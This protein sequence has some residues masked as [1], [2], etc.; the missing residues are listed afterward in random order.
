MLSDWMEL[1]NCQNI[2]DPEKF[3]DKYLE[4]DEV[5]EE[6]HTL[7]VTCPVRVQCLNYA[8]AMKATGVWGG[9]W[10]QNGSTVKKMEQVLS[11]Y[12]WTD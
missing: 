10:L 12:Y 2:D 9:K 4:S 7:C 11:Q 8:V 3:F 6:V 5:V 1:A